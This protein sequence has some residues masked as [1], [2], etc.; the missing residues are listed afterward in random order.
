[1]KTSAMITL[2][3]I[4]GRSTLG[5][6]KS[7]AQKVAVCL[8]GSNYDTVVNG[9]MKRASN[10]FLSAG[11][12][13]E[14]HSDQTFCQG[15]RD[16]AIMVSLLT[17]TPKTFHPG[18]LAYALPF[19]GVHIQ[20]FYDRIGLADPGLLPYLLAHVFV[21]EITH[22]LQGIDRH[23]IS[24][25]MKAQ[26]NSSDYTSMKRGQLRFTELDIEKIH[27]GLAA[28]AARRAL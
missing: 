2:A 25:I 17:S 24:G 11:V 20:V 22:I 15:Q 5:A 12:N 19:E 1:M 10:L 18:T 23:S 14:W 27:D 13:L 7:D 8:E 9:A 21:H 16:L 4:L 6:T 26:W 28:R 3:A